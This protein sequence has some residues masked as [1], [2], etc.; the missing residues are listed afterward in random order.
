MNVFMRRALVTTAVCCAFAGVFPTSAGASRSEQVVFSVSAVQGG[1]GGFWIWCEA[2]ST[3]PYTG[4]CNGSVYFYEFGPAEHVSGFI[5]EIPNGS[6]LY[7]I[8]VAN[9]TGPYSIACQLNNPNPA[10][11]GPTNVVDINCSAPVSFT[12]SVNAAV[13]RVTG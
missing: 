10:T 3:N 13:V 7:T 5:Q 4:A 6:G 1:G 9:T 8:T 12:G 2:E 11:T